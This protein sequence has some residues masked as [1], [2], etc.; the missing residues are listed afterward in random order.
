MKCPACSAENK[1]TAKFC[2]SCG[3]ALSRPVTKAL[4]PSTCKSPQACGFSEKPDSKFCPKCGE[5]NP[6]LEGKQQKTAPQEPVA[7]IESVSAPAQEISK[8][9]APPTHLHHTGMRGDSPAAPSPIREKPVA[10]KSAS[11]RSLMLIVITLSAAALAGGGIYYYKFRGG[12][13]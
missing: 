4:I 11:N 8:V 7:P 12:L 3:A 1:D 5:L 13:T 9:T 6:S 10:D 2:K